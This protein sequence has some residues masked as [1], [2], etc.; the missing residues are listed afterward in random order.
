M[1]QNGFTLIELMVVV[2]IVG[3]LAAV[4]VPG[5]VRAIDKAK[6]SEANAAAGTIGT[7]VRAY[8]VNSGIANAQALIGS[9]LGDVSVQLALGFGP[10]DLDATYFE[11][12]DYV[13]DNVDDS[14]NTEITATGGS[15]PNSPSGTYK[16]Q[17]DGDWVKQ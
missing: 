5:Y 7:A 2:V 12:G 3:I 15:K 6:W 1:K 13:I 14:G 10:F 8:A 9:N 11:P 16:L 4:V 17:L